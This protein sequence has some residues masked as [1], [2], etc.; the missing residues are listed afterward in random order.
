MPLWSISPLDCV[1]C[2]TEYRKYILWGDPL[3][4]GLSDVGHN[5]VLSLL[6][7]V[8]V[9]WSN[10]MEM[11]VKYKLGIESTLNITINSQKE[12]LAF[13]EEWQDC[14]KSL[15]CNYSPS[16]P[17]CM[18]F[19]CAVQTLTKYIIGHW[20]NCLIRSV[21][22]VR[23]Y[24]LIW[25]SLR[26]DCYIKVAAISAKGL[27]PHSLTAWE[28]ESGRTIE[29]RIFPTSTST[30]QHPASSHHHTSSE[31]WGREELTLKT[32]GLSRK[33]TLLRTD[34]LDLITPH[35]NSLGIWC[36]YQRYIYFGS[37]F[38]NR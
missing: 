21:N 37:C 29:H 15:D 6:C 7:I 4:R 36:N 10:I 3:S 22:H 17:P 11:R 2:N 31:A 24:Y 1:Q 5:T 19:F 25:F 35:D 8:P 20:T 16:F 38:R 13:L 28:E 23:I 18:T 27:S 33:D 32:V 9:S 34:H 30:S 14:Y 26:S 12:F